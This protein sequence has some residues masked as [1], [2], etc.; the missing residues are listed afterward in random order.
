MRL[1]SQCNSL[2]TMKQNF[3]WQNL[4]SS[5]THAQKFLQLLPYDRKK[6]CNW[7]PIAW[8]SFNVVFQTTI[9]SAWNNAL[10]CFLINSKHTNAIN[11]IAQLTVVQNWCKILIKHAGIRFYLH[12]IIDDCFLDLGY[13]KCHE[14]LWKING[15][16]TFLILIDQIYKK[17]MW[18][19]SKIFQLK[20]YKSVVI[21]F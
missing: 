19:K 11:Y 21:L 18:C 15:G 6:K 9:R 1:R 12:I 7:Q 17:E 5:L 10:I 2:P 3:R 14:N 4:L 13:F 20:K 16:I 8:S